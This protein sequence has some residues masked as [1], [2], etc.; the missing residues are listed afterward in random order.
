MQSP[1]PQEVT[2]LL[3]AW[4]DGNEGALEKLVPKVRAELQRLAKHYM[5]QER[6]G[7]L[8]QTTALV[9]EAYIR[10]IDWKNVSWQNRAHFFGVS[11][12]LMRRILVDMARSRPRAEHGGEA[13]QTTLDEALDISPKRGTDLV[14]LDDAL[15]VLAKMDS[16]KAQIVELRFFG[17]LSVEETAEV[18]KVAPVTVMR[19]WNKAK[20]WLYRELKKSDE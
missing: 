14:A 4:G 9:N 10:L 15:N 19:E 8:L 3:Q 18:L 17:G 11:A 5:R 1:P 20:A 13:H 16:R 12:Q 6:P 7:H 2:L